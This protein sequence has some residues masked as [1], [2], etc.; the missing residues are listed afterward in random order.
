MTSAKETE[1]AAVATPLHQDL[2]LGDN[3]NPATGQDYTHTSIHKGG[4]GVAGEG[5]SHSWLT[6]KMPFLRTRRGKIITVVVV[7]VVI[8]GGLAGLA[9]LHKRN[10]GQGGGWMGGG[11]GE[12]DGI[13]DDGEFYGQSPGVYPSR[14]SFLSFGYCSGGS[15]L[16]GMKCSKY[17]GAWGL[18]RVVRQG[19]GAGG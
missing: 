1:A 16:T 5:Q 4:D 9:A 13:T 6:R 18:V 19:S 15:L 7:L 3:S 12:G 8:G 11:G 14:E 10:G 17:E 2:H